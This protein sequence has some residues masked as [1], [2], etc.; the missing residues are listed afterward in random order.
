MC[1]SDLLMVL[2]FDRKHTYEWLSDITCIMLLYHSVIVNFFFKYVLDSL[3][4]S[5]LFCLEVCWWVTQS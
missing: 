2:Y 5:N 4:D 1:M 3:S